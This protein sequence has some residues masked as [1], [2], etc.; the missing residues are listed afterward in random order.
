MNSRYDFP[1][2]T[3]MLSFIMPYKTQLD[4]EMNKVIGEADQ[5]FVKSGRQSALAFFTADAMQDFATGLWGAV[6]F[7]VI[8]NGGIRATLYKG[9]VTVGDLYEIYPFNNRL[10]LVELKGKAVKQ[11]FDDFARNKME[12]FSKGVRLTL[13]NNEIDSL[14]IGGKPLDEEA[15]YRIVTVDFL[16]EGN[17][18]MKAFSQATKF[19]NSNIMLRD[20]MI[21]YIKN[22]TDKNKKIHAISDDRITIEE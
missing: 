15:V 14:T 20:T 3:K 11:L 18:G 6:D 8:N 22:L 13:K 2:N 19:I 21:D 9:P 7:A 16:A 10:V 17:D 5:N 1:V 4:A 12:G